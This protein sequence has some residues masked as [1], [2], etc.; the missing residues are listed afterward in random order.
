MAWR[1]QRLLNGRSPVVPCLI[2]QFLHRNPGVALLIRNA[3]SLASGKDDRTG[4]TDDD[5]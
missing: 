4:R 1:A 3:E 2:D 5:F